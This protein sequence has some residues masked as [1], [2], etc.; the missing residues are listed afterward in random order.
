MNDLLPTDNYV[1]PCINHLE[2]TG[3]LSYVNLP[4]IDTFHYTM[5]KHYILKS[6]Q[7]SSENPLSIRSC[8]AHSGG[9][10]LSKILLFTWKPYFTIGN[11][12]L[13]SLSD[14]L[15]SF[16]FKKNVCHI[17]KSKTLVCRFISSKNYISIKEQLVQ[18]ISQA[19]THMSF[20]Q[21]SISVFSRSV[22]CVLSILVL[23]VL[24]SCVFKCQDL[25]KLIILQFH[26]RHS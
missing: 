11:N 26:Q 14:R 21:A 1:T 5:S 23:R 8:Q 16:I 18:F 7:I 9:H 17:S 24:E 22:L 25:I 20:R 12:S 6:P 3:S 13:F 10:T 15:T 19:S 2:N 4:N